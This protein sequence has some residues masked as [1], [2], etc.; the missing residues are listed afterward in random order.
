MRIAL[1]L[2][3]AVTFLP[4][5]PLANVAFAQQVKSGTVIFIITNG[6][7][8]KPIADATV[9]MTKNGNPPS[10]PVV[11]KT[12]AEGKVTFTELLPGKYTSRVVAKDFQLQEDPEFLVEAGREGEFPI[13]LSKADVIDV[14]ANPDNKPLIEEGSSAPAVKFTPKDVRT[15]PVDGRDALSLPPTPSVVRSN[16]G[17][18]SLK[19]AREDQSAF[20]VN[21][22]ISGD[23]ATGAPVI[24]IPLEAVES[25]QIFTNPFLPEYGRFTGGVLKVETR[26]GGQKW[27]FGFNDLFPEPRFRGGKLFGFANVSPRVNF[28]GPLVKDKL[29][30]AQGLEFIVDKSP[31]RGLANPNNEIR[32]R[33]FRSFSQFDF[34]VS[35]KQSFTGTVNFAR[36]NT[37]FLGLDFFTP[38]PVAP[39]RRGDDIGFDVRHRY[40]RENGA[41]L[42]TIFSYKRIDNDIFGNGPATMVITPVGRTGNFFSTT[43]RVTERYQIQSSYAMQD[44]QAFGR[45]RVKVGFDVNAMRNRGTL[46]NRPVEIRRSNGT[47]AQRIEFGRVGDLSADNIEVSG[48]AQDQWQILP[49]LQL[50]YGLRIETQQAAT[51]VNL[52]PRIGLSYSPGKSGNSVFRV[53]YG[54][55]Y[56]KILLNA[57]A[58]RSLPNQIVT[59]FAA[60]GV[61]PI[62]GPRVFVNEIARN[63]TNTRTG[64]DFRV[65]FNSSLRVEFAQK[66]TDRVLVRFGYTDSRTFDD[67]FIT[68]FNNGTGGTVRLFNSGRATYRAF[69][70]T[71]DI[72][73]TR[74]HE[75]TVS[76]TRSKARG[77]LNDFVSYFG[78][79]PDPV[80]RPDQF[81][82]ANVD[83]PN[84]FF[85]RGRFEAPFGLTFA[86]II[87]WRD[88]FPYSLRD[89]QQNFVGN[90]NADNVRY[91]NFFSLDV[92][93]TK[94]VKIP[95]WLKPNFF[96]KKADLKS[97][98]FTVSIFNVTN[99]FNPRNVFA[100]NA[101]PQ[102]G[103][104][105][106]N[107]RRFF[108]IDFGI[109]F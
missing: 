88:G 64:S 84:R 29:F 92:A 67:F 42:E 72:K 58:F 52:A 77:Q 62:D 44:I 61:T 104:F 63:P 47:L 25:T 71:A 75:L 69:D 101:A 65:P 57:L 45:H 4:T 99:H 86:P 33:A 105:F 3:L 68:P 79:F 109:N 7:D 28:S 27:E 66:F 74:D 85:A 106:A 54:L 39:N 30:F 102:F 38:Q 23:P 32:N 10:Q 2:L 60:D 50:D 98:Q 80:I 89:Q 51:T 22:R 82:N 11:K 37:R 100:N 5:A 96:G 13:G 21:G 9:T 20:I 56:D 18:I 6:E 17:R 8:G 81:A 55:F 93:V 12:D 97:A 59:T 34:I 36:R 49:N 108:R 94:T 40:F 70:A 90:R 35:P 15:L 16:D 41:A 73:F 14:N 78:D 1:A 107:Y 76:Y 19:A 26:G 87:E 83:T 24:N 95:E 43:D 103:T 31:V 91:P 46:T 53:G 48:Y